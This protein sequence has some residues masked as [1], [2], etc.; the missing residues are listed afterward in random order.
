ML[1]CY[2][3]QVY[4]SL[5]DQNHDKVELVYIVEEVP[6][7]RYECVST[8]IQW[9]YIKCWAYMFTSVDQMYACRVFLS[10]MDVFC[11]FFSA[12]LIEQFFLIY[13]KK[14]IL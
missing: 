7:M 14:K 11:L 4:L 9:P 6:L 1:Y 2:R 13:V 5:L 10:F 3:I 8:D 12:Q